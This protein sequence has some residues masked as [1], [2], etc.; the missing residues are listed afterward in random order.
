MNNKYWWNTL[1]K[2]RDTYFGHLGVAV[3]PIEVLP[4]GSFSAT[5]PVELSD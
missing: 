4:E 1:G 2:K 3:K 5:T